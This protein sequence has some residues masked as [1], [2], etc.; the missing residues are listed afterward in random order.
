[1]TTT[2]D[3]LN[4]IVL[5][6]YIF[7]ERGSLFLATIKTLSTSAISDR[8]RFLNVFYFSLTSEMTLSE[9]NLICLFTPV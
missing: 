1:M 5:Q 7:I 8:K 3:Y 6:F 9:H 4:T 2:P